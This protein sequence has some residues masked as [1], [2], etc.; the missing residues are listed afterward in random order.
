[1]VAWWGWSWAELEVQP[2]PRD[3]FFSPTNR[4]WRKICNKLYMAIFPYE[5]LLF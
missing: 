2:P 3:D 5:Q 1:M 4:K